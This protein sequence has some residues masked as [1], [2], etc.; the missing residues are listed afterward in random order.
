MKQFVFALGFLSIVFAVAQPVLATEVE[1]KTVT[2]GAALIEYSMRGE[3]PLIV[4]I[5]STGRGT[6]EFAPLANQLVARG[7]RVALPEPRGISGSTGPME[8]VTFHDFAGDFAAVV[9]AEGGKAIVVGHAYGH[10][11]A[12][13][14]ASDYPEMTRGIVLLAGA[15]KSWPSELSDAIMVISDPESTREERLT[16]L[17]LAFFA[18]GN[19]PTPWLE[20]WHADV[21]KSQSSARELTNRKDWWAGGAVPILDLRAGSDPFRPES[22]RMEAK[23]EFGNRVT[24]AVI[25]GASHALPAE[26][27]IEAADAIADWSDKLK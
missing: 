9:A 27:P 23:D 22:S 17:R 18:A 24:V 11:I 3:G 6:A 19:D 26:K 25:D 5:A 13:T 14:I 1:Q 20:G 15:A 10:W 8:N 12:K 21:I 4:M 2:N 16:K 7:Y